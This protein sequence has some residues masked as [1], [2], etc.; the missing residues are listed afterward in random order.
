MAA[1]RADQILSALVQALGDDPAAQRWIRANRAQVKAVINEELAA[2]ASAAS[3]PAPSAP[4]D[5]PD[6]VVDIDASFADKDGKASALGALAL[7]AH[8]IEDP[9]K[10]WPAAAPYLA[11]FREHLAWRRSDP[12]ASLIAESA[13][14]VPASARKAGVHLRAPGQE[15][16][17]VWGKLKTIL[18]NAAPELRK[19]GAD[20]FAGFASV[21]HRA[22]MVASWVLRASTGSEWVRTATEQIKAGLVAAQT[23]KADQSL[24]DAVE[25]AR[26]LLDRMHHDN[27]WNLHLRNWLGALLQQQGMAAVQTVIRIMEGGSGKV[28]PLPPV[29]AVR[30]RTDQVEMYSTPEADRMRDAAIRALVPVLMARTVSVPRLTIPSPPVPTPGGA[31]EIGRISV[32]PGVHTIPMFQ[33]DEAHRWG[34]NGIHIGRLSA[35]YAAK[36]TEATGVQDTQRPYL[37]ATDGHRQTVLWVPGHMNADPHDGVVKDWSDLLAGGGAEIGVWRGAVQCGNATATMEGMFPEWPA[38]LQPTTRVSGYPFDLRTLAAWC[39]AVIWTRDQRARPVTLRTDGRFADP[40]VGESPI[41]ARPRDHTGFNPRYLYDICVFLL[42]TGAKTAEFGV[43]ESAQAMCTVTTPD[44]L[45]VIM[46]MR[47]D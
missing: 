19:S 36:V 30:L 40:L 11:W 32:V 34:L 15:L 14:A 35:K 37:T 45:C 39:K 10:T 3:S 12:P 47:L 1:S 21:P 27:V 41:V 24:R 22:N 13:N 38:Y 17:R 26:P 20:R 8:H 7:I 28:P 42:S 29:D 9:A 2:A 5:E 43:G 44:A 6:I 25:Q 4:A 23:T 18:T 16:F 46:P 31:G 33:S